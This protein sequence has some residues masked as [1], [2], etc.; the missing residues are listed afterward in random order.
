[1]SEKMKSFGK[2][3][4]RIDNHL[5]PLV[6]F[7][8]RRQIRD[9]SL[10]VVCFLYILAQSALVVGYFYTKNFDCIIWFN[11]FSCSFSGMGSFSEGN[12]VTEHGKKIEDDAFKLIPMT[13]WE[14]FCG[15]LQIGLIWSL[16]FAA[17]TV[18]FAAALSFD[19]FEYLFLFVP[20]VLMLCVAMSCKIILYGFITPYRKK[21]EQW[22]L[23]FFG[24]PLVACGILGFAWLEHVGG[25]YVHHDISDHL[26][27]GTL[28]GGLGLFFALFTM[29]AFFLIRYYLKYPKTLFWKLISINIG[30]YLAAQSVFFG[31]W[32]LLRFLVLNH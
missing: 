1:M 28:I 11:I 19:R 13:H 21:S 6:V 32:F 15:R 29:F 5:N 22:I 30:T 20:P 16:I 12:I 10:F 26:V 3:R 9:G 14:K 18:P 31:G 17:L 25:L 4:R 23:L 8:F 2:Y 27:L 24:V 7:E